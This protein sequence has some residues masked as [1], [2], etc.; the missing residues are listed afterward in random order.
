MKIE[1]GENLEDEFRK[2]YKS[3]VEKQLDQYL[4]DGFENIMKKHIVDD[5]VEVKEADSVAE[6]D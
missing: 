1:L 5:S 3:R 6:Q 4:I 2:V